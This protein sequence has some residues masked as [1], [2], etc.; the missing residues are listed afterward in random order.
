MVPDPTEDISA[1]GIRTSLAGYRKGA[2][3]LRRIHSHK[4]SLMTQRSN[5]SKI[6][7]I[8]ASAL[9]TFAGFTGIDRIHAELSKL[10][11]ISTG[12]VEFAFNLLLLAVLILVIVDLVYRFGDRAAAHHRSIVVLAGFI[13]GLDD[14]LDQPVPSGLAG[15]ELL[16]SIHERYRLVTEVLPPSTDEEYLAAKDAFQKKEARKA[17]IDGRADTHT[18]VFPSETD[19]RQTLEQIVTRDRDTR[20]LLEVLRDVDPDCWVSGGAVRNL[21][22]DAGHDFAVVTPLD[23]V[24]VVRFDA[25]NPK[26]E[27]DEALEA[28]L[29]KAAPNVK[30]SVKNQARMH[31]FGGDDPYADLADALTKFPETASALAVRIRKNDAIEILAPLGLEDLFR[32]VVRPT[33]YAVDHDIDRFARRLGR[34]WQRSWPR[35]VVA[36]IGA[37]T[38]AHV[39]GSCRTT[40]DTSG[41]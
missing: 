19:W 5:Q 35:L 25:D 3:V 10:I 2:E 8:V 27:A 38:N 1:Q 17:E 32:L 22:W 33:P 13:R 23:D 36:D 6:V 9:L 21:V 14:I 29:S 30:W 4:L 26:K 41:S 24:D 11:S 12:T 18:A 20:R 39:S 31:A 34:D 40:P 28:A 7:L 16:V 37:D 15:R